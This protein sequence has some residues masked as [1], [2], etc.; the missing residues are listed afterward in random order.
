MIDLHCHLLDE[1]P[2]GA[3]SFEASL[4]ICRQASADDVRTIVATLRWAAHLSEPPLAFDE[5]QQKLERLNEAMRGAVALRSGF[6]M[7]FRS[8]L[9]ALLDRY[10]SSITLGGGR[11][12]F[13]SLPSLHVPLDV[14]EVW[15]KVSEKGFS[16]LLARAECSPVL[17]RDFVRLERWIESGLMLQLDAAS[18][19][20]QHGHE[21]QHFALQCVKKYEGSVVVASSVGSTRHTPLAQAREL[22]LKKNPSR[23]VR[24]LFYETPAMMISDD[25]NAS[26]DEDARA[27]RRPRISRLRALRSHRALPDES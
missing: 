4:E 14:D 10:G 3:E 17:R 16:I 22:L 6:L 27:F 11:Y 7:E 1:T 21:I 2:H 24:R 23:R 5:C 15:N 13:V 25:R 12:V 26:G 9:P 20:G 18:I 19:T 8:D